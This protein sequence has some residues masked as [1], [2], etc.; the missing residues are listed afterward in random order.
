MK[1][2]VT[3]LVFILCGCAARSFAANH[4]V[5][6][7]ADTNDGACDADCSLR[8]AIATAGSGDVIMFSALFSEPQTITLGLGQ[9][10]I[11]TSL[12]IKGPGP[13][14]LTIS[15]NNETRVF[16]M[17][18]IP[19]VAMS[20]LRIS[21]GFAASFSDETGGGIYILNSSLDL[22]NVTIANNRA[23]VLQQP[24]EGKGGGIYK[25]G[26]G[27]LA[28]T[29]CQIH[30]NQAAGNL[31]GLGGGIYSSG[32]TYIR[33][34]SI[35]Y[36]TAPNGGGGLY[37]GDTFY[38]TNSTVSE[39]NSFPQGPTISSWG[40]GLRSF[41]SATLTNSTI[42][43]N[44]ANRGGGIAAEGT[45]VARNS[46]VAGN[47][48]AASDAGPD[49]VGAA[50]SEGHN[51]IGNTANNSGWIATDIQNVDPRLGPLA[52]NGGSTFTHALVL[53]SPALNAGNNEL[54]RDPFNNSILVYDQRGIGFPRIMDGTVDIGAYEASLFLVSG[55]V[56]NASGRGIA[57][58]RITFTDG[59]A[60]V[61]SRT[62]PFGYYR[63]A[64]IPSAA[65]NVSVFHKSY[66]FNS[67]VAVI[68]DGKR[69]DL[70][71]VSQ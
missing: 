64:G 17:S 42:T 24:R 25:I 58:A 61:Y 32:T 54:A 46:I 65:Y 59:A 2:L 23:M 9:L 66:L 55:R 20:G 34:S 47:G 8:E 30:N 49:I 13:D 12:S 22:T 5:T 16:S 3:L 67:P 68:I 69:D 39:N 60:T 44:S 29:D 38:L 52:S 45:L 19:R 14:L 71:F 26:S 62:N 6:K 1:T 7:T 50:T 56:T 33:N 15:G 40:G 18:N 10:A 11:S 27:S 21:N 36:N 41:G 48:L 28:I 70:N 35:F 4:L 31:G 37:V 57:G 51:L 53:G 43:R 63:F